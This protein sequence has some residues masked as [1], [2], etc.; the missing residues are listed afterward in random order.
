MNHEEKA[1]APKIRYDFIEELDSPNPVIHIT[2]PVVASPES[3][4]TPEAPAAMDEPVLKKPKE[5][6]VFSQVDSLF[7]LARQLITETGNEDFIGEWRK[8][9][10][11]I[12]E[13]PVSVAVV[14]EF[15]R[16]KST[17]INSLLELDVLPVGN[18]PTTAI[19][20]RIVYGEK[21]AFI[22]CSPEGSRQELPLAM[23][24]W[25]KFV[26]NDQGQ[27]PGG[28][29]LLKIPN[30]WLR[31]T[32]VEIIDTPGAGDLSGKRAALT[33]EVIAGC[34]IALITVSALMALSLTEKA[35]IEENIFLKA[36]PQVAV[37]LTK[38]DQI[39]EPAQRLSVIG[40]MQEKV[41]NWAPGLPLWFSPSIPLDL[42][43][44]SQLLKAITGSEAIR[45]A[46]EKMI[47]APDMSQ[48]RAIQAAVQLRGLLELLRTGLETKKQAILMTREQREEFL[49][50]SQRKLDQNRMDWEELRLILEKRELECG[51]WLDKSV[52]Q[53]KLNM[54]EKSEYSLQHTSNPK[55]WWEQDLPYILRQEILGFIK[56]LGKTL[57]ERL[58]KDASWIEAQAAKLFS[59][60]VTLKKSNQ[61]TVNE[62][63]P[64]LLHKPEHIQ[65][66]NKIRIMTRI[67]VGASTVASYF[68]FGP[69]GTAVSIGGGIFSEKIFEKSLKNQKTELSRLLDDEI[70]SI[71]KK[72]LETIHQRLHGA[73]QSLL[74]DLKQQEELWFKTRQ[75]AL[76]VKD[77]TTVE[78]LQM[79]R[80]IG[81]IQQLEAEIIQLIEEV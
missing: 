64:I 1:V 30:E 13:R 48:L 44:D 36:I 60:E 35:F 56:N 70:S 54:V 9:Y 46:L 68:L 41:A 79:E 43:D 28:T 12:Y 51:D 52:W 53:A 59:W 23:E 42:K 11:L 16:G 5:Q 75:K 58:C 67:G 14:G 21:P 38:L 24:S 2:P 3:I 25:D 62:T 19:L 55:L 47:Q 81:K 27:D 77:G 69:L 17:F 49:R 65:D 4:H 57:Q 32:G 22:Y 76:A 26:A 63:D 78:L 7:T 15:S 20:T 61:I 39:P 29:I 8:I 66:I 37:V 6:A 73:Y 74:S 33:T 71:L 80:D 72:G 18:L 31:K 34:D 10:G 50:Q 40:Y 45:S